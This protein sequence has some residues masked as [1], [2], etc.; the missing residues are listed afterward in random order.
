MLKKN[1]LITGITFFL[2]FLL[3]F[4]WTNISI[5]LNNTDE[6]IGYLTLKNYN[7]ANDTIRYVSVILIPLT[8]YII[9]NLN[10][11]KDNYSIN[12]FFLKN[13][14]EKNNDLSILELNKI[15]L[16]LVSYVLIDFFYNVEIKNYTLDNFH[17]GDYLTAAQNYTKFLKIWSSSISGHGGSNKIYPLIGWK[18]FDKETIGAYRF[19]LSVLILILKIFS[20]FLALQLVKISN[21]EKSSKIIFFSF[22]SIILI[23]LSSYQIPMNYSEFSIRDLYVVIFL[24]FLIDKI[25]SKKDNKIVNVILV[26]IPFL[27]ITLHTDT[28][29]Y[30][31]F[32]LIFFLTY[33]AIEKKYKSIFEIALGTIFIFILFFLVFGEIE[34]ASL[35]E[36]IFL[37]SKNIDLIH[38]L[39]FPQPF[40]SIGDHEHG[41]R[42]TKV[43]FLQFISGIFIINSLISKK[44]TYN[45]KQKITLMMIFFIS[46]IMFKNALGRSDSYHIRMSSE[47]PIIIF[48]FFLL[49][50]FLGIIEKKIKIKKINTCLYIYAIISLL[51]IIPLFN[52]NNLKSIVN[53]NHNFSNF[54]N[55]SDEEFIDEKT[56]KFLKDANQILKKEECIVNFTYDNSLNY[57]LK[58][59]S[60]TKYILAYYTSGN[61]IEYKYIA[62]IKKSN[63]TFIIYNTPNFKMDNITMQDRVKIINK[64]ILNRYKVIYS[65]NGYT[66]MKKL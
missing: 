2:F 38:G 53:F 46:F 50:N 58:K 10:Y 15:I 16:L 13:N 20:I 29:I 6:V 57:L 59:P 43:I 9:L 61:V 31:Y 65:K 7:P 11:N 66:I 27:G 56:K 19:F 40:F 36:N 44:T 26:I 12:N 30:L 28:G 33:L 47:W 32:I 18:L 55:A 14:I 8:L 24:I 4:F 51:I 63:S 54:I 39:E 48:S 5:P 41:S 25:Y 23:N 52:S 64:Y 62:D 60:C 35:F 49:E 42:A 3:C 1:F 34:T 17:D 21:L 37:I 45:F 22:L